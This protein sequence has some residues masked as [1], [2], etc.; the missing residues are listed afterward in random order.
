[1]IVIRMNEYDMVAHETEELAVQHYEQFMNKGRNAILDP[2]YY[3]VVDLETEVNFALPWE[4]H[5][6]V[7]RIA[8]AYEKGKFFLPHVFTNRLREIEN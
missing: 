5:E 7:M 2:N 3:G 1:M 4:D 6:D 8:E